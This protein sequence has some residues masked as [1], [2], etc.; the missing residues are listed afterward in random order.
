[1]IRVT[2]GLVGLSIQKRYVPEEAHNFKVET[3]SEVT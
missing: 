3:E 1:M 2:A